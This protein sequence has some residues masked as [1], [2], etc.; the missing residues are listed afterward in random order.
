VDYFTQLDLTASYKLSRNWELFG[1]VL[2]VTNQAFRVHFSESAG[3]FTQF[4][5]YGTSANFGLRWKL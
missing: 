2:N 4:E 1:E 3:R 5:E